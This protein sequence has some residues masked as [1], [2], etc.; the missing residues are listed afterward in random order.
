MS[1]SLRKVGVLVPAQGWCL[2]L[3][4]WPFCPR[5]C[6]S[7][8]LR[9]LRRLV[10]PGAVTLYVSCAFGIGSDSEKTNSKKTILS[11]CESVALLCV[12]RLATLSHSQCC[13]RRR[14]R[15]Q[16]LLHN[17][18]SCFCLLG[19]EVTSLSHN[20]SLNLPRQDHRGT[21]VHV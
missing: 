7:E 16:Q 17:T 2:S 11:H 13:R 19:G 6:D 9:C 1:W 14:A 18:G 4:L 5:G 3:N 21:R 12:W 10:P 20:Q 8:S 15:M